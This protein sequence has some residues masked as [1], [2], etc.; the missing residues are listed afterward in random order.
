MLGEAGVPRVVALT[1]AKDPPKPPPRK[2]LQSLV[3]SWVLEICLSCSGT[4]FCH[5]HL[6][7]PLTDT[8]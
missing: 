7:V 8:M 3:A 5:T 1:R 6:F 4:L 2:V